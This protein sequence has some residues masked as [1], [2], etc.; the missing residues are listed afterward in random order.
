MEN[1]AVNAMR[2]APRC[3]ATSKRSGFQCRAAAVRGSRVCRMHGAFAGAPKGNRNARKH[4]ERSAKAVRFRRLIRELG[5]NAR[6]L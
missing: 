4:G 2:L 1:P 5:A 6:A 3:C